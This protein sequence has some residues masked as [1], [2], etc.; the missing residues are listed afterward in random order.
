MHIVY[1]LID[2]LNERVGR[3]VMWLTLFM[4]LIQFMAVLAIFVFQANV[5][6]GLPMPAW[7]EVINMYLHGTVIMM[8]AGYTLLH[9]GHVR[10]DI[11]YRTAPERRKDWTNLLGS[12]FFTL[13]VCALIYWASSKGVFRAWTSLE[14][15]TDTLGLPYKYAL[16]TLLL[17]FP[18]LLGL[19]AISIIIK[20]ILR[21]RGESVTDPYFD[22]EGAH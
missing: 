13:P 15:S 9:N 6:F 18:I 14:G 4:V 2:Q 1:R 3:A 5:V 19:Q 11:F 12:L 20:C 21:L 8:A 7:Q 22:E 16:K 17:I 10:I